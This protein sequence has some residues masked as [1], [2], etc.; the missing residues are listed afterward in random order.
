MYSVF[1]H[2]DISKE[3]LTLLRGALF[4][5]GITSFVFITGDPLLSPLGQNNTG[6]SYIA[7][8]TREVV[9]M[10]QEWKAEGLHNGFS[11]RDAL[12]IGPG[13][14]HGVATTVSDRK[15]GVVFRVLGIP[16]AT[17]MQV[18]MP[19][20]AKQLQRYDTLRVAHRIFIGQPGEDDSHVALRGWSVAGED[21]VAPSR[22]ASQEGKEEAKASTSAWSNPLKKTTLTK[23]IVVTAQDVQGLNGV[24][25]TTIEMPTTNYF[26]W[27]H[28]TDS[29]VPLQPGFGIIRIRRQNVVDPLRLIEQQ[30]IEC[31]FVLGK[32][33]QALVTFK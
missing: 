11:L 21:M 12:W 7:V 14:P 26:G 29:P 6:A 27:L 8:G 31:G 3:E 23:D 32:W 13:M 5:D 2:Q 22:S 28:P 1:S 16:S 4:M 18:P 9:S 25:E 24:R 30:V 19:R 33:G 20:T 15:T 10:V 17:A